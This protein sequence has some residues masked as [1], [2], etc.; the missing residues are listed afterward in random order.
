MFIAFNFFFP[1]LSEI[2]FLCCKV[3]E[4]VKVGSSTLIAELSFRHAFS[5]VRFVLVADIHVARLVYVRT[6]CVP[7]ATLNQNGRSRL[8]YLGDAQIIIIIII[9]IA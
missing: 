2:V 1:T 3:F 4:I 9:I 6:Y 5:L 8:L 7:I